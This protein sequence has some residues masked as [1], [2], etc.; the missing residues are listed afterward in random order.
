MGFKSFTVCAFAATAAMMARAAPQRVGIMPVF[1]NETIPAT[2][3]ITAPP[4]KPTD[5]KCVA[6]CVVRYPELR[7]V[8]WVPADQI[9]YN[10]E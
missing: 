8:S 6:E 9:T 1:K 10:E 3:T 5:S 7:A 4:P 2:P